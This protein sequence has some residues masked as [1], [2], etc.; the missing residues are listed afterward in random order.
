MTEYELLDILGEHTNTVIS[1][2][3]WWVGITLGIL[4]AVH[5]IGK[6]LN[7]YIVSILITLYI[8]FTAMISVMMNAHDERQRLLVSDLEQLQEQGV[9]IGKM[10]QYIVE[11]G[12]PPPFVEIFATVGYWGLIISTIVYTIYCFRKAKLSK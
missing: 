3:Q 11:S 9:P 10:A 2:L 1:L 12:G 8:A 7:G 4:V 5:V 6:G